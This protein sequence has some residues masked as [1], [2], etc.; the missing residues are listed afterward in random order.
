MI[1]VTIELIPNGNI[2]TKKSLGHI[3][4]INGGTGTIKR[5]N[6]TYSVVEHDHLKGTNLIHYIPVLEGKN[7]KHKRMDSVFK[8]LYRVL[9]HCYSKSAK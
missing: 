1:R 6:Y 5:G 2:E 7:V 9:N 3:D 8:L 4:I